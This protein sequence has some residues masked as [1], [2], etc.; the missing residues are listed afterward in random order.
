MAGF[1]ELC[2]AVAEAIGPNV[3]IVYGHKSKGHN[4]G[5]PE[6]R[7]YPMSGDFAGPEGPGASGNPRL[8]HT[9]S[10]TIEVRSWGVDYGN[11]EVLQ[12]AAITAIRQVVSGANYRAISELWEDEGVATGG[13]AVVTTLAVR[14]GLPK[15]ALPLPKFGAGEDETAIEVNPD[16]TVVDWNM[17]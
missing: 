11:A 2:D 10:L 15:I 3:P 7:I 1:V 13:V 6:I 16:G 8:L 17:R 12:A 9:R 14:L 5:P 4:A